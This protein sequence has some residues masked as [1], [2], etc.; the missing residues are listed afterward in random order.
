MR[1]PGI[2]YN[3]E[4]TTNITS[5]NWQKATNIAAPMTNQGFG[6][7]VFQFRD[8]IVGLSKRF[9]RSVYPSY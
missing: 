9:Y 5:A 6:I 2:T 4:Y 1:T 8:P 7:G 3:I